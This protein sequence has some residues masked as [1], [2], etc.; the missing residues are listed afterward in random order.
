M[1]V[2]A[3]HRYPVHTIFPSRVNSRGIASCAPF[4]FAPPQWS[5]TNASGAPK[6]VWTVEFRGFHAIFIDAISKDEALAREPHA[7]VRDH[8]SVLEAVEYLAKLC[9]AGHFACE[10]RHAEK[11]FK[12]ST[13]PAAPPH[14]TASLLNVPGNVHAFYTLNAMPG[15]MGLY[16]IL[17][18]ALITQHKSRALMRFSRGGGELK[19]ALTIADAVQA[20]LLLQTFEGVPMDGV[21]YVLESGHVCGKQGTPDRRA[22]VEERQP[23]TGC[24]VY[25]CADQVAEEPVEILRRPILIPWPMDKG[26]EKLAPDDSEISVFLQQFH[27]SW[28]CFCGTACVIRNFAEA[29][30]PFEDAFDMQAHVEELPGGIAKVA[31]YFGESAS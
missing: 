29:Y 10:L 24:D 25:V 1:I 19:V 18:G 3:R 23:F 12:I 28:P 27:L 4:L 30:W 20:A 5:S 2:A 6:P 11:K 7:N 15:G 22:E 8:I 14:L 13:K 16:F 31:S 17:S 9:E 21:R 26:G